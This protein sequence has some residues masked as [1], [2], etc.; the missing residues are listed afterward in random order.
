MRAAKTNKNHIGD[1][2]YFDRLFSYFR[3]QFTEEIIDLVP[4]KK[5]VI[6]LETKE[7]TYIMKG[8]PTIKRL[9]L[10]EA[11]TAT[12]RKEGF[13]KTYVFFSPP[14][15]EQLYFEGRYFGCMEYIEPHKSIFTFQSQ[16][17]RQEGLDLLEHFHQ[18]TASFEQ[19]YRTLLPH[20]DLMGKWQERFHGF[21]NNLPILGYFMKEPFISEIVEWASW[22]LSG[23][24]L[25]QFP[26]PS[27]PS[28]ILHGDV[29]H[30]NF[31]LDKDGRLCLI[32]FDLINIGPAM[33]DYL[34]YANRILPYIDWSFEK[35]TSLK[36]LQ[37]YKNNKAFLYALAY[38]ADIFREW[39]RTI[40][41]KTYTNQSIFKQVMNLSIGQF[42]SRKKF[43][44]QLKE[45]LN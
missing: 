17:N 43:I 24:N 4:I 26:S 31:L 23:L 38:P 36:Q 7:H 37:K 8:Y 39:N 2:A 6:L 30:H 32:D 21:S 27:E 10:Q 34:Q 13:S 42:Y 28:V 18:A 11:F 20:G 14:A 5:S 22:S 16:K 41:E 15:K 40:R 44:D 9:K 19:R 1:D 12:L 35:L 45:R 3:S 33:F 29:A 25:N